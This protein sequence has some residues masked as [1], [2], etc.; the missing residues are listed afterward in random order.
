MNNLQQLFFV[1]YLLEESED[2]SSTK[3]KDTGSFIPI[4]GSSWQSYGAPLQNWEPFENPLKE[5]FYQDE[6]ALETSEFLGHDL[7]NC[8]L[9]GSQLIV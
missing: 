2:V 5:D 6:P 1:D 8:K 7:E 9:D 3:S 4:V